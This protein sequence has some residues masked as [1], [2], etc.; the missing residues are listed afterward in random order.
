MANAGIR[1]STLEKCHFLI[2]TSS[3]SGTPLYTPNMC[4]VGVP[5]WT[6]WPPLTPKHRNGTSGVDNIIAAA[7]EHSDRV[8]K[9]TQTTPFYKLTNRMCRRFGSSAEAY[10]AAAAACIG[11]YEYDREPILPDPFLGRNC[12]TS[13]GLPKLLLSACHSRCLPRLS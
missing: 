5:S 1:V 2:T 3:Q 12:T 13:F 10:P 7:L 11:M 4:D 9:P 6:F 8:S